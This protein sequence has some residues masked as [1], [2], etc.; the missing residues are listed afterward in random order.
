MQLI[1]DYEEI[2]LVNEQLEKMGH[3]IGLSCLAFRS[4]TFDISCR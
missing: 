2:S 1:K 4:N 3:N